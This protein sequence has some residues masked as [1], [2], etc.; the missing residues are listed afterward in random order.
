[1]SPTKYKLTNTLN[2]IIDSVQFDV[3]TSENYNAFSICFS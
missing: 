2:I 1:M 3:I